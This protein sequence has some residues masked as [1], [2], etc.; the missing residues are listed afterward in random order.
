MRSLT[1]RY[2]A[3]KRE[4]R[5]LT[6]SGTEESR[7][8]GFPY[9]M[10]IG[11]CTWRPNMRKIGVSPVVRWTLVLYARHNRH[12]SLSHS[13]GCSWT[14]DASMSRRVRLNLSTRPFD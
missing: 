2:A 4:R 3:C 8:E 10:S 1:I 12:S 11:I 13:T 6:Y 5:S 7:R 14:A 9:I